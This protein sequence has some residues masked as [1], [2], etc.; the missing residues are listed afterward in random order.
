MQLSWVHVILAS[1]SATELLATPIARNGP[2]TNEKRDPAAVTIA[3]EPGNSPM[4]D[5][6]IW[7]PDDLKAAIQQATDYK[8]NNQY[9]GMSLLSKRSVLLHCFGAKQ[10]LP[11]TQFH[12]QRNQCGI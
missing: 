8:A 10:E 12:A 4:C 7:S 1:L 11:Q 3:S 9:Q 5:S 6:K 2:A